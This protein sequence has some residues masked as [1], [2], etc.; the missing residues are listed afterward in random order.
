MDAAVVEVDQVDGAEGQ[1]DQQETQVDDSAGGAGGAKAAQ[2][3]YDPYE[4]KSAREL[5]AW[6][7][8]LRDADPANARHAR[9]LKNIFGESFALRKEIPTGLDGVREMKTVLDS[10]IHHDAE[11]GELKGA[12]AIAAMQDTVR[13]YAEIDE[14]L[15][16][17][18]PSALDSLG[19]DFN[20]GLAKLAPHILD[21]VA[22][23]DPEAYAAA[24][25]PHFVQA[26]AKSDLVGSFNGLVDV[27]NEAPPAWLT[28]DQKAAFARDQMGKV[29][30]LAGKMGEWLNAQWKKAGELPKGGVPRGTEGKGGKAD[31]LAEREAKFNQ[32]E[33]DHHWNT[34]IGPKLDQH[35]SQSFSKLFTP[36]AKR[37]NLDAPTTNALKMEFSKRVGA[38]AIKDK[39]YMGQINRYRGMRNPDPSTVLNFA[40]VQ[41]DKNAKTVMDSLVNER[42][43]PFLNG[44]PRVTAG[45]NGNGNGQAKA[46]QPAPAKGVQ[47]V[48]V[49]PADGTF[50]N[51]NR[52]LNDIHNK[53]FRLNNGRVVQLRA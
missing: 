33:Q 23:S 30:G 42:Y 21:R 27:L 41:F 24:V 11:R 15:A 1:V 3:T 47:V 17:G 6:L 46:Q 53:I 52:S 25:L 49:R 37:L 48:T 39:A 9:A 7:K 2:D 13:E 10:V 4:S 31:P 29:I 14:K 12:E 20:A 35:A 18:D 26:L 28:A 19:E 44:K 32:R 16:Q 45:G 38:E 40:R 50:D 34:N 51:R 43:K 36:Y 5:S 22:Q 8:G